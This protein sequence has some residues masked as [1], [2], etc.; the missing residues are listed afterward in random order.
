[1]L[2]DCLHKTELKSFEKI[3]ME[4]FYMENKDMRV[5]GKFGF[6]REG[7]TLG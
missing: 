6:H 4:M 7:K 3:Y 5:R 2:I 1:M